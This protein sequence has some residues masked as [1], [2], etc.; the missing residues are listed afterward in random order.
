MPVASSSRRTRRQPSEDISE[1][2]GT[3]RTN[4][5]EDV[6]IDS[7]DD[8]ARSRGPRGEGRGKGKKKRAAA[9]DE[10]KTMVDGDLDTGDNPDE[11]FDKE[12][13]LNLPLSRTQ[14]A[15]LH[16]LAFDTHVPLTGY[17]RD[18]MEVMTRLAGNMAEFM[19]NDQDKVERCF[20]VLLEFRVHSVNRVSKNWTR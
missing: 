12:A 6:E 20:C 14:L 3:Q 9:T 5:V 8:A 17:K 4:K 19:R 7:G 11:P 1:D 18:V 15:K 10:D 13:F 16:A 2:P